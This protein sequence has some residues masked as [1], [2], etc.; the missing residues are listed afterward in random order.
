MFNNYNNAI[1]FWN[2][3]ELK[4]TNNDKLLKYY[5]CYLSQPIIF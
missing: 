1:G 2:W 3:L 5:D 4:I